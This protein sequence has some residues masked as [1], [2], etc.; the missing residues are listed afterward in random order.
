MTDDLNTRNLLGI[1]I[2]LEQKRDYAGA[3][4]LFQQLRRKNQSEIGEV[5]FH[6]G[7]CLEQLGEANR[8]RA[9][10]YY[11]KASRCL[12]ASPLLVNTFF[13]TGWLSFHDKDYAA[14]ASSFFRAIG[15]AERINLQTDLYHN[16][17]YWYAVSLESQ[18]LF[19]EA[20]KWYRLAIRVAPLF[21]PEARY[22]E[23]CCLNQIG[24]FE[25]ALAGCHAFQSEPPAEFNLN[26]YKE[27]RSLAEAEA[28]L[29]TRCLT[30]QMVFEKEENMYVSP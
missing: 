14:A 18:G 13:R 28:T 26:R 20:L 3:F 4:V 23:I 8:W 21:E 12:T 19:L 1:A 30:Q 16:S 17:V 25:D 7:W 11:R 29:L 2:S 10:Q 15:E 9:I 22:R 6:C 5:L 27:L 24:A